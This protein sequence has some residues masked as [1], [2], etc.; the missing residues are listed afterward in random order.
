MSGVQ[1]TKG[2]QGQ[3]WGTDCEKNVYAKKLKAQS[4]NG[5]M[6]FFNP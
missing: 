1:G 5:H 4:D 6:V 3:N 2:E